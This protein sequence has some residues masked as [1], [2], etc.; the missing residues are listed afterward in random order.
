M[1]LLLISDWGHVID[2][3]D[4]DGIALLKQ[5]STKKNYDRSLSMMMNKQ[6]THVK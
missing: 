2:H 3:I 6:T 1:G 5:K 4:E